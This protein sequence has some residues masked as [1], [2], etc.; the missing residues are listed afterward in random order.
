[1]VWGILAAVGPN[2]STL[3]VLNMNLTEARQRVLDKTKPRCF[4]Y[5]K[6]EEPL[7]VYA[8]EEQEFYGQGWV[9]SPAKFDGIME[10]LGVDKSDKEAV[11]NVRKAIKTVKD[12]TNDELN[13]KIM[14]AKELKG[15]AKKNY[16]NMKYS[17]NATAKTMLELI[18]NEKANASVTLDDDTLVIGDVDPDEIQDFINK[19]I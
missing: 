6:G 9:D 1:M 7:M 19:K 14:S 10:D 16:P 2:L 18:E 3:M 5:K 17:K 4:V 13:L 15:Y 11:K 12:S 8:G